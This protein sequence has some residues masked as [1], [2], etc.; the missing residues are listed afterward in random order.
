MLHPVLSDDVARAV[1]DGRP[2]VALESTIFS[3]LGLPSPA[4]GEA[5]DRCAAAIRDGGAIPA[6]RPSQCMCVG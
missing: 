1:A 6:R 3:N 2:V 4:N 5:L